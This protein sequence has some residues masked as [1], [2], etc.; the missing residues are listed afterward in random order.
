L[1]SWF[2][3]GPRAWVKGDISPSEKACKYIAHSMYQ[4]LQ[5]KFKTLFR[6]KFFDV[7]KKNTRSTETS[8]NFGYILNE[9]CIRSVD[10]SKDWK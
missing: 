7:M 10:V 4:R 1:G 8:Y 2:V 5:T 3:L 6:E 9:K